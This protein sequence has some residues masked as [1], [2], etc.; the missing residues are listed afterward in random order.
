MRL[1]PFKYDFCQTGAAIKYIAANLGDAAR[2]GDAG[3]AF[4]EIKC[5]VANGG[6]AVRYVD[7]GQ[8]KAH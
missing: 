5:I 6:D 8:A 3:Q 4:A 2:Y 1:F 7:T